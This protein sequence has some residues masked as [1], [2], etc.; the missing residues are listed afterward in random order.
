MKLYHGTSSIS[1]DNILKN[2]INLNKGNEKVDFGKGFYTTNDFDFAK[3]RAIYRANVEKRF[4]RNSNVKPVVI[5]FEI[6]KSI[7]NKEKTKYK[8]KRFNGVNN[9]WAKFCIYNRCDYE[10]LEKNNIT[11]HNKDLKYDI[12]IGKTADKKVSNLSYE[13]NEGKYQIDDNTYNI[14]DNQS[15]KTQFS[16]HSKEVITELKIINII[17][18]D[19]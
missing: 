19:L 8:L 7:I 5:E 4:N 15:F 9:K 10:F 14:I 18:I 11:F 17:D 6:N 13:F 3:Q 2:G 1:A 12:V 16:F